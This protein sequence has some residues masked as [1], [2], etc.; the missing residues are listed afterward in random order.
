MYLELNISYRQGS[1]L[2]LGMEYSSNFIDGCCPPWHELCTHALQNFLWP[3]LGMQ[4]WTWIIYSAQKLHPPQ[5]YEQQEHIH[6]KWHF[7][8]KCPIS[9]LDSNISREVFPQDILSGSSFCSIYGPL[10]LWQS[11]KN[12][13]KQIFSIPEKQT[14]YTAEFD[15][16]S[17]KQKPSKT[18]G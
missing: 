15:I 1:Q 4:C 5:S 10:V 16:H 14:H 17:G 3:Q 11:E 8:K 6:Y 9:S 7:S 12:K 18:R 13:P 2:K